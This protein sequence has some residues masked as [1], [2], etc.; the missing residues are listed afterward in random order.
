MIDARQK[1]SREEGEGSSCL[2]YLLDLFTLGI[3][4]TREK[5]AGFFRVCFVFSM[6]SVVRLMSSYTPFVVFLRG[7]S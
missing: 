5:E 2:Y 7:S 6:S 3:S 4:E 1:D